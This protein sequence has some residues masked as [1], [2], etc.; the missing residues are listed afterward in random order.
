MIEIGVQLPQSGPL[1]N[2]LGVLGLAADAEAAGVDSV[3]VSDHVVHPVHTISR[4]PY[5]KGGIPFDPSDGY[6]E[7]LVTLSAVA[8]ATHTIKLGTS[9]LVLAMRETLLAAK[10]LSTLD[11]LSNGRLVVIVAPGWWKEEFDALGADFAT[12]GR[13]LDEQLEALAKLWTQGQAEMH[14]QVV[15]FPDVYFRP[16]PQ[17]GGGPAIWIGG[18]GPS[19]WRRVVQTGAAGWHGI[20][21]N[22]DRIQDAKNHLERDCERAGR[23]L[24]SVRISIAAVMPAEPSAAVEQILR[25]H[26]IGV[27]QIVLIP[28]ADDLDVVRRDFAAFCQDALPEIWRERGGR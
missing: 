25:L 4:Y 21:W 6:L 23:P 18:S 8:G 7:A 17:Q 27:S 19:C 12:R 10:M 28:R 3:W 24:E 15:E 5:G 9:V 14:G 1:A 13:R 22:V 26:S 2:R 11:V 16:V 20:G